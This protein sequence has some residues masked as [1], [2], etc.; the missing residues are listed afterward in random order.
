MSTLKS[1]SRMVSTAHMRDATVDWTL[2]LGR[3]P[4]AIDPESVRRSLEGKRVLITGA[5]GYIGSALAR[6]LRR[7]SLQRLV[8]LDIAEQGLFE[9]GAELDDQ[10]CLTQRALI[11]GDV[12]DTALLHETFEDYQPHI[13]FHAA[14]CKHVSLMEDNPFAAARNN[15]LGTKRLLKAANEASAEQ[16]IVIS[17][18]KA[19]DP[20]G[21]MGATKRIGE[22]L[23]LANSGATQVK[24]VRLANVLGSTGSVGPILMRQIARGGPLTITDPACTRYFLSVDEVMHRLVSSLAVNVVSAVLTSDAGEPLSIVDLAHFLVHHLPSVPS[25]IEIKY[26]GLRPGDKLTECMIALDESSTP[27]NV[28]SLQRVYA[29]HS[30]AASTLESAIEEMDAAIRIRNLRRLLDAITRLVPTYRP[31]RQL[32]QQA[33]TEET[34]MMA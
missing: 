18:D 31:S 6:Y 20:I 33:N 32:Q 11:V 9:L 25:K 1:L 23:V 26:T 13:V 17:T 4:D 2:F 24:A 10:G 15:I 5:G 16:V 3:I 14:A 7:A 28:T 27:S 12:C 29:N 34:E 30:I 22:L 19:V 8:L 21:I